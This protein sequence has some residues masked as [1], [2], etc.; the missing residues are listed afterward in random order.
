MCAGGPLMALI[1]FCLLDFGLVGL[2]WPWAPWIA[3]PSLALLCRGLMVFPCGLRSCGSD[4]SLWLLSLVHF[5][6]WI[7]AAFAGVDLCLLSCGGSLARAP[8][9]GLPL[10][11]LLRWGVAI[12]V[13]VVQFFGGG[14]GYFS[15]CVCSELVRLLTP[16]LA[17]H[18][19]WEL[20]ILPASMANSTR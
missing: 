6:N 14:G 8:L 10:L 13:P 2:S 4:L 11:W 5:P 1:W 17:Q 18:G 3:G 19:L 12:L 9:F 15:Q 7:L 20:P 16:V